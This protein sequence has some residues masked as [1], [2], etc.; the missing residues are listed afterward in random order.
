[1]LKSSII[2]GGKYRLIRKIGEGTFGKI[3]EGLHKEKEEHKET[4][5]VKLIKLDASN[6]HKK[7]FENE[8]EVYERLKGIKNI[9]SLF[10][11]GIEGKFGY[12]VMDMFPQSLEELHINYKDQL[13]LKVVIHLGLEMMTIIEDI[14]S[15][16]IIHRDLKPANF[17]LKANKENI[18]ELYLIDFGLSQL[19]LDDKHKHIMMKTNETIVGTIRYMSINVHQGFT[20]SRRDDL[21]TLGYILMYLYYGELPWQSKKQTSSNT[22]HSD[23]KK[24]VLESKERLMWSK[25]GI[26][27]F[28]LFILY[29][30]N[31]GYSDKP[32]YDYLKNILKNMNNLV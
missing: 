8:I 20:A 16:G 31:L 17:L 32:C 15:R 19:F 2:V 24:N 25:D 21:E 4:V 30:R 13:S 14:H 9:P 26:N 6:E 12:I 5:A 1:M 7:I 18:T 28:I 22:L 29:C 11:S 3:Y 10:A 23:K 27:D